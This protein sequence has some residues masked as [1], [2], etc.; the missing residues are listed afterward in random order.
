MCV[1]IPCASLC[2]ALSLRYSLMSSTDCT[3]K[4]PVLDTNNN[5]NNNNNSNNK[6]LYPIYATS[7]VERIK[8]QQAQ[9]HSYIPRYIYIVS[10]NVYMYSL[11]SINLVSVNDVNPPNS[12]IQ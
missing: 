2:R 1:F 4:S 7:I 6:L 5:N 9:T 8:V 12:I 3:T 10:T 11:I